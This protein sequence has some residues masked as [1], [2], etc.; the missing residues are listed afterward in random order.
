MNKTKE[1]KMAIEWF[2]GSADDAAITFR[3]PEI[4]I[5]SVQTSRSIRL[6]F[7]NAEE[8]GKFID[9]LQAMQMDYCISKD[10]RYQREVID[11]QDR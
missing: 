5:Y 10:E 1:D 3:G 4:F 11:A 2:I 6:L 9:A 7:H 8:R